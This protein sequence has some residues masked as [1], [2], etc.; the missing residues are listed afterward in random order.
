MNQSIPQMKKQLQKVR[1]K[2]VPPSP[3][4]EA[5]QGP[6]LRGVWLMAPHMCAEERQTP[7]THSRPHRGTKYWWATLLRES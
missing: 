6:G 5:R 1:D 4:A 3:W 2:A 7:G